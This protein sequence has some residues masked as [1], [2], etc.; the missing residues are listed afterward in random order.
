MN[1]ELINNLSGNPMAQGTAIALS[2]LVLEDPVT[3]G[4]GLL[5][6]DG[7]IA[8]LTALAALTFGIAGGDIALYVLG[9]CFGRSRFA[10]RVMSR[11]GAAKASA[12]LHRNK[13][14]ALLAARFIPGMRLPA[15]VAAGVSGVSLRAFCVLALGAS[16]FWTLL[17]L[18]AV[19]AGGALSIA[20]LGSV[21]WALAPAALGFVAT[22]SIAAKNHSHAAQPRKPV[23]SL[24]EF[25]PPYI[26]YIPVSIY[27]VTLAIR[28]RSLTL[29]TAANPAIYAG[30]FV[31]ESKSSI[32]DL[33]ATNAKRWVAPHV[34]INDSESHFAI[35]QCSAAGFGFPMVAKPDIGQRG[36]G[37]Q[38]LKC[39]EHLEQYIADFPCE[40]ALILQQLADYPYEAGILYYRIPG[41]ATGHICSVTLK[42]FPTVTGDGI[43]TL[44]ELILSNSR[45]RLARKAYFARLKNRLDGVPGRNEVVQ[46]V[47]AG[48]HCQGAIF[49]NGAQLLTP[50]LEARIE[51]IAQAI[52]EFFF[53]RFDLRFCNP[54]SLQRGEEFLI[55]EING[56][57][58]EATHI[59]DPEARLID[60]YAAL[61]HQFKVLFQI[62]AANRQRGFR[63]IGTMTLL[64]D[65]FAYCAAARKYPETH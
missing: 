4:S 51:E 43:S 46:L 58:A 1:F 54:G 50:Q 15:Y 33:V 40:E 30:G 41:E 22:R 2:T 52:P 61:F 32:L 62:G 17:L 11:S 38:V 27:Y 44:R 3:F 47:F 39:R 56:A 5:V 23:S 13:T 25:W 18:G 53:G 48:N 9:R 12:W 31:G 37:V 63:S 34:R 20:T 14:H 6:A 35:L 59:W 24:F 29:P 49:R 36:A 7:R 16:F 65:F 8:F 55:V 60:A 42:E 19:T 10:T 57:G 28:H 26:F 45:L 21:K 64:R